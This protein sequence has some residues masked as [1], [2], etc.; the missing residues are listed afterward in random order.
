MVGL[1]ECFTLYQRRVLEIRMQE[2]QPPSPLWVRKAPL[3][4]IEEIVSTHLGPGRFTATSQTLVSAGRYL[5]TWR[6]MSEA[7]ARRKSEGF[8]AADITPVFGTRFAK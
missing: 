1:A 7:G 4:R 6:S 2:P 5:C 8:M 3:R